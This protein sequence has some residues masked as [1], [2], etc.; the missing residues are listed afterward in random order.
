MGRGGRG[1]R[2]ARA[3]RGAGAPEA[4]PAPAARRSPRPPRRPPASYLARCRC[5]PAA[6]LPAVPAL[7]DCT[8]GRAPRAQGGFSQR[9]AAP[10]APAP[11]QR[12]RRRFP[13]LPPVAAASAAC[14]VLCELFSPVSPG[15][16]RAAP[17]H[18]LQG[19]AARAPPGRGAACRLRRAPGRLQLGLACGRLPAP[20]PAAASP[21]S[22][23]LVAPGAP[24]SCLPPC[25]LAP[26]KPQ[27]ARAPGNAR[28][29]PRLP[30]PALC[31]GP[32][33]TP[34]CCRQRPS[35]ACHARAPG[36]AAQRPH[37]APRVQAAP[38][39][40]RA[41]GGRGPRPDTEPPRIP[42]HTPIPSR[43]PPAPLPRCG[44][45]ASGPTT[46]PRPGRTRPRSFTS[47]ARTFRAGRGRPLAA[48]N[49]TL[50]RRGAAR[51]GARA[52][53]RA[54][55]LAGRAPRALAFGARLAR[56]PAWRRRAEPPRP[57]PPPSPQPQ[58]S[59]ERLA[60][61]SRAARQCEEHKQT[62][63]P[64]PSSGPKP[65]T[66][67]LHCVC[68][69]RGGRRVPAAAAAAAAAAARAAGRGRAARRGAGRAPA[70]TP[71]VCCLDGCVMR[72]V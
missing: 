47:A 44:T 72:R 8:P 11:C 14:C 19:R 33:F 42:P 12:T 39:A 1:A 30:A 57:P 45:K 43:P 49:C 53:A 62:H 55:P 21:A 20:A 35:P 41:T 67:H 65:N 5:L 22:G 58:D 16:R 7:S 71:C 2:R 63:I 64:S 51:R 38:A 3:T 24:L 60:V 54:Q 32:V 68:R 52:R 37:G 15:P 34:H 18:A 48:P 6:P 28:P 56:R 25:L 23:L 4:G 66:R 26:A 29:A 27:T 31:P 9:P 13:A 46:W 50:A 61:P 10:R 69:S 36:T 59:S 40:R 17:P 70:T